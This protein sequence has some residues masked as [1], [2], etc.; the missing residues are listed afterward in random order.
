MS[1]VLRSEFRVR[2]PAIHRGF[3]AAAP[4]PGSARTLG[5]HPPVG[6]NA[7]AAGGAGR[8]PTPRPAPLHQPR[9]AHQKITLRLH[10]AVHLEG[11][12]QGVSRSP[13]LPEGAPV[14][15]AAR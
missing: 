5:P 12:A 6:A 8:P 3:D 15:D 1:Q 13:A 7:R 11:A 2:T 4:L 10:A 14:W 9:A